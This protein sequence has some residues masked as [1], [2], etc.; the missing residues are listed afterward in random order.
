MNDKAC[1]HR[2]ER[3]A[4][5][6]QLRKLGAAAEAHRGAAAQLLRA[7]HVACEG[8]DKACRLNAVPMQT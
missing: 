2:Q 4:F 8:R 7:S 6:E 5:A 1:G 3:L